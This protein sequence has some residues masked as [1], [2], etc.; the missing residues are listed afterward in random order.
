MTA[1]ARDLLGKVLV[2]ESEGAVASAVISETEAYCESERA[3]HAWNRRRTA[4]TN[5]LFRSG[6]VAYVY[7]CYGI[8]HLFNVVTGPED[9]A[10]AVL[11][12][13]AVPLEGLEHM[14][15]RRPKADSGQLAS[16]PGNL[17]RALGI[18]TAWNGTDL[19]ARANVW[20]EDRKIRIP[21]GD[22]LSGPRIGVDY[23]G[24]DAELPWRFYLTPQ[25]AYKL[26]GG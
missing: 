3:C 26:T 14:Q 18:T 24:P 17:S 11:I 21:D 12:R 5:M 20:L 1:L 15:A 25:A 19:T 4:R 10:Q 9:R 6:G 22:I 8:H 7:L 2:T 16:G 13:G 23:A